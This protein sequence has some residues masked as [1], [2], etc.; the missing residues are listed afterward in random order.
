MPVGVTVT[1][2]QGKSSAARRAVVTGN[3]CASGNSWRRSWRRPSRPA[4]ARASAQPP[5]HKQWRGCPVSDR[6]VTSCSCSA[7]DL[8]SSTFVR[9]GA[10][11]PC[12]VC[13]NAKPVGGAGG[14]AGNSSAGRL[15]VSRRDSGG[16]VVAY[17]AARFPWSSL[18][19]DPK[20][21][22]SGW[23]GPPV[24]PPFSKGGTWRVRR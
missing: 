4:S 21:G 20:R 10:V 13:V 1:V 16:D 23:A 8:P 14:G 18:S 17:C 24:P 15:V 2:P 7:L 22:G 12:G 9:A 11:R 19:L 6:V 3:G 5:Q